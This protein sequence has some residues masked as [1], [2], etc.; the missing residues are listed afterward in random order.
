MRNP[1]GLAFILLVLLAPAASAQDGAFVRHT[2]L[3]GRV[4]VELP[5]T[6]QPM[7]EEMKRMK[8]PGANAPSLAFSDTDG[9]VSFAISWTAHRLDTPNVGAQTRQLRSQLDAVSR[10]LRWHGSEVL[11]LDGR[12]V[13][14]LDFDSKAI[15][16]EI[17]NRMLLTSL[18]GRMLLLTFNMTKELEPAWL[19]ISER[20]VQSVRFRR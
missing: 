17:R 3:E 10:V 15:D 6:L 18:E 20:V 5:P 4:T 19:P 8:Y 9:T 7:S 2:L 12:D 11:M 13:G 1:F 16:T 14:L